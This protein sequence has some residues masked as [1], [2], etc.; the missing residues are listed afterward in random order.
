MAVPLRRSR[1]PGSPSRRFRSTRS[2]ASSLKSTSRSPKPSTT[3][4]PICRTACR[5]PPVKTA[6]NVATHILGSLRSRIGANN[7]VTSCSGAGCRA[8]MTDVPAKRV[9]V[10]ADKAFDAHGI[11]TLAWAD[12]GVRPRRAH[13]APA[14]PPAT[15][16]SSRRARSG[17]DAT[18]AGARRG[19]PR[20]GARRSPPLVVELGEGG[21]A[22]PSRPRSPPASARGRD[23]R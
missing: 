8:Y 15:T 2:R 12:R 20:R 4:R 18:P 7:L 1:R 16:A 21:D 10:D 23:M 5:R 22:A 17:S 9:I 6:R 19:H 3:D 13:L 11:L 14:H